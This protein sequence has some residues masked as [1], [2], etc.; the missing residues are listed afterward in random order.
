MTVTFVA[1]I[2]TILLLPYQKAFT[3]FVVLIYEGK[4]VSKVVNPSLIFIQN[5]FLLN[6]S[7]F[8]LQNTLPCGLYGEIYELI[9]NIVKGNVSILI[10][11]NSDRNL[12]SV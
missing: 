9:H 2:I 5:L 11:S 1:I 12:V 8:S 4:I 3:Q 10:F 7:P 6:Y